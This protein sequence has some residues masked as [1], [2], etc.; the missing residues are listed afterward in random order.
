MSK[1]KNNTKSMQWH[2]LFLSIFFLYTWLPEASIRDNYGASLLLAA[3]L[4]PITMVT[5]YYSIYVTIERFWLKKRFVPFWLNLF[6]STD[7]KA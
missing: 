1:L 7:P 6:A 5:T 3:G 2:F 4:V